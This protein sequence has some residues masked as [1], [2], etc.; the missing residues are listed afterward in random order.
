MLEVHVPADWK[1]AADDDLA[2]KATEGTPE[3]LDFVN[4]IQKAVNACKGDTLPVSAFK[5]VI[6]GNMPQ[7]TAAYEKRGVAVDVPV[8][9]SEKC[10]QCNQC[11]FVCPHAAIRPVVLNDE[12][13]NAAPEG[14]H[15]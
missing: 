15:S 7:G 13:K 3:V 5:N 4:N 1:N 8:W 6:D 10:I 9:E 11:S 14:M 12:E 2:S